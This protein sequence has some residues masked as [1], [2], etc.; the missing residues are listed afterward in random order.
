M[1]NV[2]FITADQW[3]GDCLGVAGHPCL[4]TPNL[5]ALAASGVRFARHYAQCAPCGPSRASLHTGMY[6]MNHRSVSNGTPLDPRFTNT[7][8]EARRLGYDAAL[9]GYTDTSPDPRDRDP[10]DPALQTYCGVLPGFRQLVPGSEGP[11]AWLHHLQKHGHDV[12]AVTHP[13]DEPAVWDP[14]PDHPEASRRGPT[15]ASAPYP[16]E[17]SDTAFSTDHAIDYIERAAGRP[18]FLHLSLLRPHPPFIAPAPWHAMYDPDDGPAFAR[19]ASRETEA[20]VHPYE[21]FRQT[22]TRRYLDARKLDVTDERHQRQLRAT[23]WGMMSEVDHHLGRLLAALEAS[24]EAHNTLVV[25]TSDHGEQLLDHWQIGKLGYQEQSFHVPLIIRAPDMA[26]TVRGSV[27]DAFTE[28]VDI[29]PTLVDWLG[30]RVPLQAD[31]HSLL[32]WLAGEQPAWRT[33]ACYELDFRDVAQGRAEQALGCARDA[34]NFAVL[35]G[36]HWKYVHFADLPPLLFRIDDDPAEL[37]NLADEPEYAGVVAVQCR[38]L[39]SH[40]Q[41][42]ADRTWTHTLVTRNGLVQPA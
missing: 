29:M 34:C 20:S 25:F 27:V 41:R 21:R 13:E 7:A 23:Y 38:A 16:A 15:F 18:W 3:R 4:Q 11:I 33:A 2:L 30:G 32:P 37:N 26:P 12:E 10:R 42:H 1:R 14:S 22:Q 28:N 31:G 36:E 40:R 39:L 17:L 8:L 24:G 9:I 35:R 19:H 6:Q 5:D